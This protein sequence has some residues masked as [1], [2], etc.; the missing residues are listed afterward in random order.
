MQV[1]EWFSRF[2]G[3]RGGGARQPA[4]GDVLEQENVDG[5]IAEELRIPANR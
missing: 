3:P 1:R 4:Q 5:T 2:D